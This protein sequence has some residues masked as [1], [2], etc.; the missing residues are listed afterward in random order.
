[1]ECIVLDRLVCKGRVQ[2]EGQH[3]EL[4]FSGGSYS[5]VMGRYYAENEIILTMV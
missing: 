5:E 1:M 2:P 3:A 4:R